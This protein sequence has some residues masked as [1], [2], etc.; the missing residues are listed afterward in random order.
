MHV[1]KY[2]YMY[3]NAYNAYMYACEHVNLC[4]SEHMRALFQK[5]SL[6]YRCQLQRVCFGR[7][8]HICIYAHIYI[9]IYIYI[10]VHIHE[11]LFSKT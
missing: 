5:M 10:C 7:D 9:D 3:V 6:Q 1:Y 4:M 2:L 11:E 8:F